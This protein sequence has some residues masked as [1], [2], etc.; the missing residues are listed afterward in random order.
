MIESSL[1]TETIRR[2]IDVSRVWLGVGEERSIVPMRL[3]DEDL[4]LKAL[5]EGAIAECGDWTIKVTPPRSIGTPGG[6]SEWTPGILVM[7]VHGFASGLRVD[8]ESV[9]Q[10]CKRIREIEQLR[11]TRLNEE[12]EAEQQDEQRELDDG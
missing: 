2:F 1:D 12:L 5:K 3:L 9:R 7:S 10:V 11:S 6:E 4:V 8:A